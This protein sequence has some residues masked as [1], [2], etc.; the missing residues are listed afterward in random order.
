MRDVPGIAGVMY[1]TWNSNYENLER[2][3]ETW[4]GGATPPPPPRT[5]KK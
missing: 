4:W 5:R 2:F 3:A 1:T